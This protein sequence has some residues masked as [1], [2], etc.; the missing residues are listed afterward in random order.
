MHTE[1]SEEVSLFIEELEVL[2]FIGAVVVLYTTRCPSMI[3][4]ESQYNAYFS[5]H[6][7]IYTS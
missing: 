2:D 1:A 6:N 5:Y 4:Q 3:S 7:N